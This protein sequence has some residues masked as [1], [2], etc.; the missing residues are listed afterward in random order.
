MAIS[1]T[2]LPQISNVK[3]VT[4][5]DDQSPRKSFAMSELYKG[6]DFVLM[7]RSSKNQSTTRPVKPS[8]KEKEEVKS[9]PFA[10]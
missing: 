1:A 8:Q 2:R 3:R 10:I 9:P 5:L 7:E 4:S 6:V